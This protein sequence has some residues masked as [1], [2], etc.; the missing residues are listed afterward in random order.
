MVWVVFLLKISFLKFNYSQNSSV[1]LHLLRKLK[2]SISVLLYLQ[3]K[4]SHSVPESVALT[5]TCDSVLWYKPQQNQYELS[6]QHA[7]GRTI[8]LSEHNRRFFFLILLHPTR[9]LEDDS[10]LTNEVLNLIQL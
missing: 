9:A 7:L 3:A 8:W 10:V 1:L 4:I 2:L 6:L 5:D